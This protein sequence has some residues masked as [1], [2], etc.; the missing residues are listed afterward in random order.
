MNTL[1]QSKEEL[2]GRLITPEFKDWKKRKY[3]MISFFCKK[4]S[5]FN[6]ALCHRSQYT[7]AEVLQN[8]D[9]DGYHFNLELSGADKGV[10]SAEGKNFGTPFFFYDM[11]LF[12]QNRWRKITSRF[13]V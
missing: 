13:L 4:S 7:K 9:Y 12:S 10:F 5:R 2:G 8:F 11:R 1:N 3:K 6:G